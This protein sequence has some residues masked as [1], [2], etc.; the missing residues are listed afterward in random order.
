[1]HY[2]DLLQHT[3]EFNILYVEDEEALRL[4]IVTILNHLFKNVVSAKDGKEG[5]D[6]YVEYTKDNKD[7]FDIVLTDLCMPKIDGIDLIRKIYQ[8]NHRQAIVVVSAHNDSLKLMDLINLGIRNFI[9]KPFS[10]H[11]FYDVFFKVSQDILYEKEK[12]QFTIDREL[13]EYK[14]ILLEDKAD[15]LKDLLKNIA[16]H[17]RQPLSLIS[18]IASGMQVELEMGVYDPRKCEKS[19]RQIIDTT[20]DMSTTI[21]ALSDSMKLTQDKISFNIKD[22]LESVV[23]LMKSKFEDENITIVKN[24]EDIKIFHIEH[25]LQQVFINLFNNA[26]DAMK[27]NET[28]LLFINIFTKE[29]NVHI[30][31]KDNGTGI[32]SEIENKLCDPYFTTKHKYHGTG[33]GLFVVNDYTT[34]EMAGVLE[35]KNINYEYNEQKYS[36]TMVSISFPLME[37]NL[38]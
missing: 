7:Y 1:M 22:V 13:H 18:T 17:W 3:K 14:K 5:Y 34:K 26:I 38:S 6:F 4:E 37:S 28:K 12:I 10:R 11:E 25:Q 35:F 15:S 24:I 27:N 9:N 21:S 32:T 36:G 16:H 29:K 31:I 33:L 19:L 23:F 2:D 20:M 30:E 8:I